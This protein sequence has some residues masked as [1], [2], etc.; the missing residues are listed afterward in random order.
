M[1]KQIALIS[2]DKAIE[3][4]EDRGW[5][6]GKIHQ[7]LT[8]FARERRLRTWGYKGHSAEL[9]LID[10]L[11]WQD[12]GLDMLNGHLVVPGKFLSP[13]YAE[14]TW[15]D[16]HWDRQEIEAAFPHPSGEESCNEWLMQLMRENPES[17]PRAKQAYADEAT[18]RFAVSRR[19]FNTMWAVA[20]KETGANWNR[21]G[22]RPCG[23]KS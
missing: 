23:E 13:D 7:R 5:Q 3:T 18:Q 4:A 21:P 19:A 20:I 17:P 16:V 15:R 12:H 14:H 8:E 6:L 9:C 1:N 11:V 2:S 10:P 22:R